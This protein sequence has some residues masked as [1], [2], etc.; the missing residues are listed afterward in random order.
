ML[1]P[2]PNGRL[3]VSAGLAE[4]LETIDALFPNELSII[5]HLPLSQDPPGSCSQDGAPGAAEDEAEPNQILLEGGTHRVT[6]ATTGAAAVPI[7][8]TPSQPANTMRGRFGVAPVV[9]YL[10]YLR[11]RCI[12]INVAPRRPPPSFQPLTPLQSRPLKHPTKILTVMM[13]RREET[14]N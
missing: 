9:E 14:R 5:C 1:P 7:V 8:A 3:T 12:R 13:K 11:R 4:Q 2:S 6:L 10:D